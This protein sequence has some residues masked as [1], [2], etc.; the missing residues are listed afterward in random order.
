MI[1]R[2]PRSTL[3]PY[4]TLFRSAILGLLGGLGG[5]VLALWGTDLLVAAGGD[6][7]PRF[8]E[9]SGDGRGLLFTLGLFL[10]TRLFFGLVPA[11]PASR[12]GLNETPQESGR[13]GTS[14]AR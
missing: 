11:P 7:L 12:P 5:L 4:T 10:L 8:R 9:V 2:P 14:G 3:F 6:N 13:R 1:R